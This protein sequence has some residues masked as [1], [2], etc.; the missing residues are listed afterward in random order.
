MMGNPILWHRITEPV[1]V[2]EEKFQ[3]HGSQLHSDDR[4]PEITVS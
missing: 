2:L 1:S 3:A 4:A